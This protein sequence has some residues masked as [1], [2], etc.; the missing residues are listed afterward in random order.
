MMICILKSLTREKPTTGAAS[1]VKAIV[2]LT[3]TSH[4]LPQTRPQSHL[5]FFSL[6]GQPLPCT[7]FPLFRYLSSGDVTPSGHTLTSKGCRKTGRTGDRWRRMAGQTAARRWIQG[8]DGGQFATVSQR[9]PSCLA[10]SYAQ[11]IPDIM[12]D[13][14]PFQSTCSRWI[15]FIPK[16][17]SG[18]F[19]VPPNEH[20]TIFAKKYI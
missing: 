9:R 11:A 8:G 18:V 5:P 6:A 17:C 4:C 10:R 14:I 3:F 12:A 15:N 16:I 7:L 19:A 13:V 2:L 1:C 20:F